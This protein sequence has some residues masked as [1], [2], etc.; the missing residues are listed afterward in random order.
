MGVELE[1]KYQNEHVKGGISHA[2]TK[3]LDWKRGSGITSEGISYS[4]YN[5][6]PSG[7]N[8]QLA[9]NGNDLNNFPVQ[10]SKVYVTVEKMPFDLFCHTDVQFFWGY[11]GNEN[12]VQMYRDAYSAIGGNAAF[13]NLNGD[14]SKQHYGGFNLRWN[15]SAGKEFQYKKQKFKV[16]VMGENL[17]GFKRYFYSSGD[18]QKYPD[19]ISWTDEP[20]SLGIKLDY[21]FD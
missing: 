5:I 7:S 12:G 17:L 11:P 19:K 6:N 16:T 1:A 4:D 21:T 8:L 10:I 20:A 18:S 14:L 15:V 2:I 13:N 3:Q 9:N